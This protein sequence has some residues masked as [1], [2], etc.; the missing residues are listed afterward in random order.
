MYDVGRL[1]L[2]IPTLKLYKYTTHMYT[3]EPVGLQA[4]MQKCEHTYNKYTYIHARALV[5]MISNN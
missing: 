4:Y 2:C 1:Y 3:F 5:C